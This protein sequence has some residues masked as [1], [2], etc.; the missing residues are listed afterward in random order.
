MKIF[1]AIIFLVLMTVNSYGQSI[2]RWIV[3]TP[4]GCLAN[5]FADGN[6][7]I[8]FIG[9]CKNNYING[10]GS[11]KVFKDGILNGE[12]VGDFKDGKPNGW[13]NYKYTDGRNIVGQVK[14]GLLHGQAIFK[15]KEGKVKLGEWKDNK[16]NGQ[17]IEFNADGSIDKSGIY[18]NGKLSIPQVVDASKFALI[19]KIDYLELFEKN[20]KNIVEA[21]KSEQ[22]IKKL[23][24]CVG[25]DSSLWDSCQGTFF[26]Q[27]G[28]K[29]LSNGDVYTG[30]FKNGKA[31]G[32]GIF[33][34]ISGGKYEGG[35]KNN[36]ADGYGIFTFK[37]GS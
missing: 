13:M 18:E 14:D 28:H 37:N 34:F 6:I 24:Y 16:P 30:E 10:Q 15:T 12:G 36:M 19:K 35:F 29:Y 8:N 22:Q 9:E 5:T 11:I 2:G 31:E 21:N 7:T 4:T 3:T 17:F 27:E 25:R 33:T 20:T 32:K 1:S 26:I 23:P